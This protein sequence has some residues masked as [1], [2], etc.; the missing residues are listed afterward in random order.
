MSVLMP[1]SN[2]IW[3]TT[4]PWK[5]F[6]QSL[7]KCSLTITV[8]NLHSIII[9][10]RIRKYRLWHQ[11]Q[12]KL[13][14]RNHQHTIRIRRRVHRHRDG[15]HHRLQLRRL[16]ARETTTDS[17]KLSKWISELLRTDGDAGA[18][19]LGESLLHVRELRRPERSEPQQSP[20]LRPSP[21]RQP[22]DDR[23]HH[24]GIRCSSGRGHFCCFCWF[25]IGL[26]GKDWLCNSLHICTGATAAQE[27]HLFLR[28][29][30]AKSGP[31]LAN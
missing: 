13:H 17:S 4:L 15:P 27:H 3:F 9:F 10:C 18:E 19:V 11:Q 22:L 6:R 8:V 7:G 5:W 23:Q 25:R 29:C 31:V 2:V 21:W 30:Y 1:P 14:R 16:L 20:P 28:Q 24:Q 12:H 26:L